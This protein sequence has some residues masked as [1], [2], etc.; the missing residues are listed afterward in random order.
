VKNVAVAAFPG[1]LAFL[2]ALAAMSGLWVL[3][4]SL[5]VPLL[6]R[7]HPAQIVGMRYVFHLI[8]L[9][10]LVVPGGAHRLFTTERRGVQIA[11]GACMFIMPLSLTVSGLGF[12]SR[13]LWTLF[14]TAPL[15]ILV[16]GGLMLGERVRPRHWVLV[17]AGYAGACLVLRPEIAELLTTSA[18][19]PLTGGFCLALYVV[20]SRVLR[21]ESEA[22]SLFYTAFVSLVLMAPLM[23]ANWNPLRAMDVMLLASIGTTGLAFL[24]LLDRI[25]DF[26][27]SF[28]IAPFLFWIVGWEAVA[29]TVLRRELPSETLLIGCIVLAVAALGVF[30]GER[31]TGAS[32]G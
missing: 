16:L 29:H 18:V 6:D 3:V 19:F 30:F 11:R 9:A 21:Y 4:E 17:L 20:L 28:V 25:A 1:R 10:A 22:T 5:G 14:W 32:R 8:V 31:L 27:P 26:L 15:V 24:Y 2:T 13:N 12:A 7:Y 23:F